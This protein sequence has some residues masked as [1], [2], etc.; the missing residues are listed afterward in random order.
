MILLSFYHFSDHFR[1]LFPILSEKEQNFEM[2]AEAKLQFNSLK[3]QE[4]IRTAEFGTPFA[5][6]SPYIK[7]YDSLVLRILITT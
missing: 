5:L 4:K 6:K 2:R 1:S 7:G 3:Y